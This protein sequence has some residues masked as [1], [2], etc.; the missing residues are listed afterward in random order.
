MCRQKPRFRRPC[1]TVPCSESCSG[2]SIAY[3]PDE[4]IARTRG[5]IYSVSPRVLASGILQRCR[6]EPLPRFSLRLLQKG[7]NIGGV[8]AELI[9]VD[10]RP[11]CLFACTLCAA[12]SSRQLQLLCFVVLW[13][14]LPLRL[15]GA[16]NGFSIRSA[17]MLSL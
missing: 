2:K 8:H 13:H 14:S 3:R 11:L 10:R 5:H 9:Q 4:I 16:R 15:M 6:A 17:A 12:L 1:C 7:G